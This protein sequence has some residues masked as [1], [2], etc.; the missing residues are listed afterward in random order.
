MRPTRDVL[1]LGSQGRTPTYMIVLWVLVYSHVGHMPHLKVAHEPS[2]R[3]RVKLNQRPLTA[4]YHP[5]VSSQHGTGSITGVTGVIR[6]PRHV[7][8]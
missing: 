4:R 6:M 3:E 8:W 2:Y 1:G 5:A 7:G